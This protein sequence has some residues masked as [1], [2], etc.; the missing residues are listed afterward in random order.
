[1]E[2]VAIAAVVVGLFLLQNKLYK[3]YA[4]KNLGGIWRPAIRC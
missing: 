3:T 4:F 2:F 1:M